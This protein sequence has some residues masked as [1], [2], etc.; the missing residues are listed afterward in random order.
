MDS[1]DGIVYYW[2]ASVLIRSPS[3]FFQQL[4]TYRLENRGRGREA[5]HISNLLLV[6]ATLT[7]CEATEEH[8]IQLSWLLMQFEVM[9]CFRENL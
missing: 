7:F 5:C 1:M 8:V 2:Q 9:S 3:C 4:S 6:I